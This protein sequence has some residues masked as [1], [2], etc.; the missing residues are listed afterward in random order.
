MKKCLFLMC[1]MT[2][3][4]GSSMAQDLPVSQH[5]KQGFS[6]ERLT[7]IDTV[8]QSFIDGGHVA[9]AVGQFHNAY[10]LILPASQEI[11]RFSHVSALLE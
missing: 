2:V 3:F 1:L 8:I 6:P 4:A 11:G 10:I 9:G 7:R 5:E